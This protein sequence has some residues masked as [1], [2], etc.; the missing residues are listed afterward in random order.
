MG[1]RSRVR[2]RLH[3]ENKLKKLK[4]KIAIIAPKYVPVLFLGVISLDSKFQLSRSSNNSDIDNSFRSN[5]CH[6]EGNGTILNILSCRADQYSS[7][8]T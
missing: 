2:K 4:L 6:H 1:A 3:T 8:D 7:I 5:F